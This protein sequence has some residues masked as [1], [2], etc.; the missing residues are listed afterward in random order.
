MQFSYL[1]YSKHRLFDL[2][3]LWLLPIGFLLLLTDLYFLPGR[4]VHHKLFYG[5]F[6][7]PTLIA[8][9]LRPKELKEILREPIIL[10]YLIFASWAMFSLIW[11]NTDEGFLGELKPPLHLLMLFVGSSLLIKYRADIVPPLL[12]VAASIA[13]IAT[14]YNL[15]VFISA[16][17]PG[18]SYPGRS[19]APA[20]PRS[21]QSI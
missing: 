11:S 9:A 13:L 18:S 1:R 14:L 10:A 15:S 6:S 19:P 2:I 8:I 7:I 20:R 21:I 5:L 12:F 17:T 4:S 3:C 16:Y